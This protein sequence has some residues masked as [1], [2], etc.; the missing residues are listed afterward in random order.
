MVDGAGFEPEKLKHYRTG[1]PFHDRDINTIFG[2][3]TKK[4][5]TF[6]KN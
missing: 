3:T 2:K 1:C 4:T 6:M 5:D